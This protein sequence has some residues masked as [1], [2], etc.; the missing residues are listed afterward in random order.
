MSDFE[1]QKADCAF[2]MVALPL[3]GVSFSF[4]TGQYATGAAFAVGAMLWFLLRPT[5]IE[6][7]GENL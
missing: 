3:V 5:K 2:Y 7:K 4:A 6:R 1:K